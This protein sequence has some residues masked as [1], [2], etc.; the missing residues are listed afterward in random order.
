ML[1]RGPVVIVPAAACPGALE[2]TAMTVA[3]VGR[4]MPLGL[5]L[6]AADRALSVAAVAAFVVL[7]RRAG[8]WL[9]AVA[10]ALAFAAQPAFAPSLS[11]FGPAGALVA[12]SVFLALLS[13]APAS[14]ADWAAWLALLLSAAIAPGATLPLAAVAGWHCA[15][16]PRSSSILWRRAAMAGAALVAGV[17]ALEALMPGRP[18][19]FALPIA[20]LLPSWSESAAT[21]AAVDVRSMLTSA[22]AFAC[23]LAA[24][25]AFSRLGALRTRGARTALAYAVASTAA[26]WTAPDSARLLA[27][28][29]VGFWALVAVGLAEGVRACGVGVG[30]RVAAGVLVALVPV[31]QL[32]AR[33]DAARPPANAGLQGHERT[34]L[35]GVSQTLRMM[36]ATSGLVVEDAVTDVL[37]RALDGAWQRAGKTLQ[38][39]PR[40]RADVTV[41]LGRPGHH[42]FALPA[43]QEDLWR[44]GFRLTHVPDWPGA[45]ELHAGGACTVAGGEW[46]DLADL[47]RSSMLSVVAEAD[48]EEGPILVYAAS[49]QRPAARAV[50]WPP[51]TTRGFH[52]A[53]YDRSTNA[54]PVDAAARED[55]LPTGSPVLGA[56][57]VTRLELWRTPGA[58]RI[59]TVDLG[60]TPAVAVARLRQDAAVQ[61]LTVCPAFPFTPQPL[62]VSR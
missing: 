52:E 3:R 32:S 47:S 16:G 10:A 46:R 60:V 15:A 42:V 18:P 22:G 61:R 6:L 11:V 44:V 56:R 59:L 39:V 53:S 21:L 24:L 1:Q 51:L 48:A 29:M 43:A 28:L 36:P 8:G 20:C 62:A 45:A 2:W 33:T 40:R 4:S 58:P 23:S 57:Y 55:G 37:L 13:R 31:L 14:G 5:W 30:G 19:V 26:A 34:T 9:A 54:L 38:L 49:D 12:A 17:V 50:G 41:A 27:P 7:A 35:Q 25:G